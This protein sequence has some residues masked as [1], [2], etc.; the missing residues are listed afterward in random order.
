MLKK[1]T[2]SLILFVTLILVGCGPTI[3]DKD[4]NVI[5]DESLLSIEEIIKDKDEFVEGFTVPIKLDNGVVITW[6]SLDP[7]VVFGTPNSDENYIDVIIHRPEFNEDNINVTIELKLFYEDNKTGE[8]YTKDSNFT[9][10]VLAK[11]APVVSKISDV[12]LLNDPLY[13]SSDNDKKLTIK[14]DGVSVFDRSNKWIFIFDGSGVM[15]VKYESSEQLDMLNTYDVEG[16]LDWDNGQWQLIE[17]TF[18]E[19]SGSGNVPTLLEIDDIESYVTTLNDNNLLDIINGNVTLGHYEPKYVQLIGTI[20]AHESGRLIISNLKGDD[21][22]WND[23]NLSLNHGFV[24]DVD[25]THYNTLKSYIGFEVVIKGVISGYDQ[26][27]KAMTFIFSDV[28]NEIE[29]GQM[30]D[31]QI[32]QADAMAFHI[33]KEIK[34]AIDLNLAYTAKFGSTISWISSDE[35]ILDPV[36]GVITIPATPKVLILDVT[37]KSGQESLT[38]TYSIVVGEVELST[39]IEAKQLS[40][41]TVVKVEG[42]YVGSMDDEFDIILTESAGIALRNHLGDSKPLVGNLVTIVGVKDEMNGLDLIS[43]YIILTEEA[44]TLPSSINLVDIKLDR[45]NL[46]PFQSMLVNL[47]TMI[48]IDSSDNYAILSPLNPNDDSTI[49]LTW[50]TDLEM[51]LNVGDMINSENILVSW[52]DDE[53]ILVL[54]DITTMDKLDEKLSIAYNL[55]FDLSYQQ[56]FNEEGQIELYPIIVNTSVNWSY[57]DQNNPNN[58]LI[59]LETGMIDVPI[60]GTVTVS[61]QATMMIEGFEFIR[62][63]EFELN[64]KP[65]LMYEFDFTNAT[66]MPN[67]VSLALRESFSTNLVNDTQYSFWRE[68]SKIGERNST[69]RGFILESPNNQQNISPYIYTGFKVTGLKKI[70]ISIGNWGLDA[71]N[72]M[73]EIAQSIDVQVSNDGVNWTTVKDLK[74]EWIKANDTIN[75]YEVSVPNESN[76]AL[77]VRVIVVAIPDTV[78]SGNL[79]LIVTNIKFFVKE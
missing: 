48:V 44:G 21:L 38:I 40:V 49:Q 60:E 10:V 23:N 9:I 19:S 79:R 45:E 67:N 28:L 14:L 5:L 78:F 74:P 20:Q 46:L 55:F 36:T 1:I 8:T 75:T 71:T 42:I 12:Y 7:S 24:F 73:D 4:P 25:A 68:H 11:D 16:L 26:E 30:T 57:E 50:N 59:N 64:A 41:G 3:E 70:E 32:I 65:A 69:L 27:L 61:L 31:L 15:R 72:N 54:M 58:Q 56:S 29:Y 13:V 18:N 77:Y 43:D 33:P 22:K 53:P 63:F 47:D 66:D 2:K 52:A 76:E 39:P 62:V 51:I 35:T 37:F 17:A 6:A 34:E